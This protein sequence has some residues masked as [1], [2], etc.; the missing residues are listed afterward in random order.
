MSYILQVIEKLTDLTKKGDLTW[1]YL[2]EHLDL[3][4]RSLSLTDSIE[5][6][7]SASFYASSGTGY[8]VLLECSIN[9][10][11][12]YLIAYPS[13]DSKDIQ[14]LNIYN[15]CQKEL[16]RLQN[17]VKKNFPNVDDFLNNFLSK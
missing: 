17:L 9:I 15:Q 6:N 8:F 1:N 5:F 13:L 4:K 2:S 3:S 12:L 7:E 11:E 14:S 10:P 16:L